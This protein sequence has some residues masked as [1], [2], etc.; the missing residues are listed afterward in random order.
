M[1][2]VVIAM[3]IGFGVYY[4]QVQP[5]QLTYRQTAQLE[6][7]AAQLGVEH[8]EFPLT[9][10]DAPMALQI[11][12]NTWHPKVSVER[13]AELLRGDEPTYVAVKN[14]QA[15]ESAGLTNGAQFHVVLPKE[16][17]RSYEYRADCKQSTW[18]GEW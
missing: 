13:A 17:Q 2:T 16:P 3:I 11:M 10:L 5:R 15:L 8:G 12:L 6:G 9:Y 14:L 1:G 4:F 18:F 7:L